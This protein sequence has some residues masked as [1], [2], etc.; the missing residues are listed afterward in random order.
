VVGRPV[1]D[2]F[3]DKLRQKFAGFKGLKP[4]LGRF[5]Q[6]VTAKVMELLKNEGLTLLSYFKSNAILAALPDDSKVKTGLLEWLKKHIQIYR[7]VGKSG[8]FL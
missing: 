5:I 4:F 2:S 6:S 3:L 8:I 7:E 1:V